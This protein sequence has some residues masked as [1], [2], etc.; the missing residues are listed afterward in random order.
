MAEPPAAWTTWV[1]MWDSPADG[2][3]NI[4]SRA[5]DGADNVETPGPGVTV[6][7][8][9][10]S[11]D[12]LTPVVNEGGPAQIGKTI[13]WQAAAS[14]AC[15]K[16][17]RFQLLPEGGSWSIAR[18]W[19]SDPDWAW[20]P[21]TAGKYQIVGQVRK[22]G[23]TTPE[24]STNSGWYEVYDPT[25]PAGLSNLKPNPVTPQE[26]NTTITW[27][28]TPTGGS[29]D[30]QFRFWVWDG[31]WGVAQ[32][33]SSATTFAWT[34]THMGKYQIRCDVRNAGATGVQASLTYPWMYVITDPAVSPC[35][36]DSLVPT[37]GS[38]VNV[39]D[40]VQWEAFVASGSGT[41]EFRFW[42]YS[43]SW[44]VGQGWSDS[45]TFDWTPT[46]P[47]TYKIVVQARNEGA[48]VNVED[49]INSGAFIVQ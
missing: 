39:N 32:N 19:S 38:P 21:S 33:W 10:A 2:C 22:T 42:V 12:S 23:G 27:T 11:L 48:S 4:L 8:G 25:A 5:T 37:P 16:E 1:Y 24:D 30:Y 46:A 43:G 28:A 6:A 41:Y 18:G 29:G 31:T 44:S 36:L 13:I 20:S 9:N 26:V 45:A 3:W 49:A 7:V 47:G 35:S 17:Y 15:D 40:L 14:G 34:P